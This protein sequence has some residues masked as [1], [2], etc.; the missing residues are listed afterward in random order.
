M[1][2]SEFFT[3]PNQRSEIGVLNRMSYT[4]KPLITMPSRSSTLSSYATYK[5]CNLL[6]ILFVITY[7]AKPDIIFLLLFFFSMENQKVFIPALMK[8]KTMN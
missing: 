4:S 8:T 1:N 7:A 5:S 2:I 3:K 6:E